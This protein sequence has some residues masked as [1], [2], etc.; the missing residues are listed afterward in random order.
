M[1]EAS[2]RLERCITSV[3]QQFVDA[4]GE[5]ALFSC[6]LAKQR[7]CLFGIDP[8]RDLGVDFAQAICCP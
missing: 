6:K 8:P 2:L 5:D 7:L 1:Y 4:T 3:L